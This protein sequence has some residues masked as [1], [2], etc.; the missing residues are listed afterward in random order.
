MRSRTVI[1]LGVV[2]MLVGVI[3]ADGSRDSET[4]LGLAMGLIL[5]ALSLWHSRSWGLGKLVGIGLLAL[6]GLMVH[7]ADFGNGEWVWNQGRT[8]DDLAG[9]WVVIASGVVV[10][11]GSAWSLIE[12]AAVAGARTEEVG[13]SLAFWRKW[14]MLVAAALVAVW[15]VG[16]L[17]AETDYSSLDDEI[18]TVEIADEWSVV[19]HLSDDGGSYRDVHMITTLS[20]LD[21]TDIE[22]VGGRLVWPDTELELCGVEVMSAVD[23]ALQIGGYFPNT[24]QCEPAMVE[25]FD[26]HGLPETGCLY[27]RVAGGVDEH[28]AQLAVDNSEIEGP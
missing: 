12:G 4:G 16:I 8:G 9:N 26:E 1:V 23:G 17:T 21:E 2:G 5:L 22:D 11:V 3:L 28:C 19:T 14:W 7:L 15:V 20:T 6:S 10:L 24:E 27:V 13:A 25:A 18:E